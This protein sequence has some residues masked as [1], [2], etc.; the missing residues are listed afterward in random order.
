MGY[1]SQQQ[2]GMPWRQVTV[3][4]ILLSVVTLANCAGIGR[5]EKPNSLNAQ[6]PILILL[7]GHA[8]KGAFRPRQPL[9]VIAPNLIEEPCELPPD[10]GRAQAGLHPVRQH[11][12]HVVSDALQPQPAVLAQAL[13]GIGQ[14]PFYARRL[15]I[16][17]QVP[18]STHLVLS[19][20]DADGIA[21]QI[22]LLYD[23][24]TRRSSLVA[25]NEAGQG[26]VTAC[27]SFQEIVQGSVDGSQLLISDAESFFI[28]AF[29]L[30]LRHPLKRA[31]HPESQLRQR[32]QQVGI[33][34]VDRQRQRSVMRAL[35]AEVHLGR[36][37]LI[38]L[39]KRHVLM[40]SLKIDDSTLPM[41]A[42]VV[43]TSAFETPLTVT[44]FVVESGSWAI[45]ACAKFGT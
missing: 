39:G 22:A 19:S 36:A 38:G 3:H 34:V 1:T 5:N 21:E 13:E 40:K 15:P 17:G 37:M 14:H 32:A 24:V 33:V 45:T 9:E 27:H 30:L 20:P 25:G 23:A 43:S 2:L 8:G 44:M 7:P 6:G 28:A 16:C 12:M 11:L 18:A 31:K 4:G 35:G 26:S 41:A 29:F 10:L 42:S